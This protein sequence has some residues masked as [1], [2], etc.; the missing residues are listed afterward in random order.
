MSLHTPDPVWTLGL[1]AAAALTL[2]VEGGVARGHRTSFGNGQSVVAP[3]AD[4]ARVGDRRCLTRRAEDCL[5][6]PVPVDEPHEAVCAVCHDMWNAAQPAQTARPCSGGECHKNPVTASDFHRTVAASVL[7]QCTACHKPHDFRVEGGAEA[8]STC[9]AR[10]GAPVT[11]AGAPAPLRLEAGLDF[12]HD[13][14]DAV[15]C[16]T[17][18]GENAG[19]GTVHVR[20]RA[21]CRGCH[22]TAPLA[23]GCTSCHEVSEVAGTSFTVTKPFEIR[24]G[25]LDRPVRTVLFRHADHWQHT[26]C[27]VCHTGGID[28]ETA[29]GADCSG[30]HLEHHEP[31]ASCMTCHEQP[32]PGAHDRTAHFGCG[33]QGCHDPVPAGI[34]SAPRT[35]ELCLVCH[36]DRVDHQPERTCVDCHAL[37]PAL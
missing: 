32:A 35:R 17:C 12:G 20:E 7:T 16:V 1:A 15:A 24:I 33:G 5:V 26:G 28:L 3:G 34:E 4:T 36:Q 31:T 14:H 21:D 37:P 11:W 19:H 10:G 13:D 27:A 30:C 2:A 25:S 22:H 6:E 23:N 9:H 29:Q 8:C 18:H